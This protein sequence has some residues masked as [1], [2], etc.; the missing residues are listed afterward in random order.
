MDG[1]PLDPRSLDFCPPVVKTPQTQPQP[2]SAPQTHPPSQTQDIPAAKRAPRQSFIDTSKIVSEDEDIRK[3]HEECH[4]ARLN[5]GVLVDS[6]TTDGLSAPLVSEFSDKVA[7]SREF[8]GSQIEWASAKA[9][10]SREAVHREEEFE[11]VQAESEGRSPP[12]ILPVSET[13]EEALLADLWDAVEKLAE[14]E[15]LLE[16]IRRTKAEDDE[17]RAVL[18]KSMVEVRVDRSVSEVTDKGERN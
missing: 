18:E 12:A 9:T 17:E 16:N 2:Q 8:L 10:R 13:R 11:R 4:I 14:A 6:L 1:E 3:L 5:A 15:S 7:L